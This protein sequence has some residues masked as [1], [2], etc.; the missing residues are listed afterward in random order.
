M[1]LLLFFIFSCFL[2][3]NTI[4]N[5]DAHTEVKI[6]DYIVDIGWGDEPPV[7]GFRNFI[8]ISISQEEDGEKVG[9]GDAFQNIDVFA[10][11]GGISKE[12][13]VIA[14]SEPGFYNAKIIPTKIGTIVIQLR[15]ELD[16]TIIDV[17][18][19]IEDVES[20]A[21]LDFP[22]TSG[23]SSDSDIVSMKNTMNSLQSDIS[24][25]KS[26]ISGID[27]D[28]GQFD[29]EDAY[30]FGMIGMATG[31]AGTFLAVISIL[32]RK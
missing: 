19:P 32:K 6:D 11:S 26:T 8:V 1:K 3:S 15:G 25:I 7:V 29:S 2:I 9:V 17:Q 18:I 22:P 21:I 24:E 10:K 31:I 4:T 20:T 12:L 30:N 27:T 23:S 28:S 5:A 14:D 16:G 13:D